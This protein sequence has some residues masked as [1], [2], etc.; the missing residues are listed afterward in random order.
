MLKNLFLQDQ[1]PKEV[2]E[3]GAKIKSFKKFINPDLNVSDKDLEAAKK[4]LN[5]PKTKE[6]KSKMH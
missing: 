5:P 1:D 4:L 6:E 3:M 2:M